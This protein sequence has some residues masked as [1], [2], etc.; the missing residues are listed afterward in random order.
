M[1]SSSQHGRRHA[2]GVVRFS[3]HLVSVIHFRTN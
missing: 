3:F 1:A 2:P